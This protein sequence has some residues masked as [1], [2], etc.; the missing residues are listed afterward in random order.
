MGPGRLLTD[1]LEMDLITL[2]YLKNVPWEMSSTDLEADRTGWKPFK[3]IA[4]KKT[5]N[6]HSLL[7]V[8]W[9]CVLNLKTCIPLDP[10][11][12]FSSFS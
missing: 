12:V 11:F 10:V 1:Y 5:E 7:E 2:T 3:R 9:Q 6:G 8:I 4:K